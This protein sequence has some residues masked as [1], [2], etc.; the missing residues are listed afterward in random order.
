MWCCKKLFWS[1]SKNDLR[2]DENI[3]K[4]WTGQGV[5]HTSGCLLDYNNFKEYYK[6]TAIDF[7]KQQALDAD[8]KTIQQINVTGNLQRPESSTMFFVVQETKQKT[9]KQKKRKNILDFLQGT[10]RVL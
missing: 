3:Q 6:L 5:D 2:T 1:A 9:K 8:Q 10:V 4:T 7:I